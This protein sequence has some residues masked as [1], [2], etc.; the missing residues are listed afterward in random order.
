MVSIDAK[1]L[2]SS[3]PKHRVIDSIEKRWDKIKVFTKID[4]YHFMRIITMLLNN[5]Y[6]QYNG[7]FWKQIW[8]VATGMSSSVEMSDYT[9]E[10][11]MEFVEK[12]LGVEPIFSAKYVDDLLYIIDEDE[13]EYMLTLFNSFDPHM[14]FT[15]EYETNGKLPFLDVEL[16]RMESGEIKTKWYRKPSSSDTILN[17]RSQHTL[18]QKINVANGLIKRI[19]TLTT[20]NPPT[21]NLPL[22]KEILMKN[23]YPLFIINKLFNDYLKKTVSEN[24]VMNKGN[25]VEHYRSIQ[26]V[27]GLSNKLAKCIKSFTNNIQI[28]FKNKKTVKSLH[29][30]VKDKIRDSRKSQL[31]YAIQCGDCLLIYF[32]ITGKYLITR[33]NQHRGDVMSFHKLREKL[34]LHVLTDLNE[35]RRLADIE[36]NKKKKAEFEKLIKYAEK[37]GITEHHTKCQHKINFKN[38]KVV[39]QEKNRQKLEVLEILHIKSNENMNKK[40]DSQKLKAYD[41][42]ITQLKNRKKTVRH[43]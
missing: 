3:I 4:K 33:I 20:A 6:C 27:T 39:Q 23:N 10:D 14:E 8:G 19:C 7:K 40:E 18:K 9:M 35:I 5:S 17:Y 15:C 36:K 11:V 38:A 43:D 41:G 30:K 13:V 26:M 37:S 2:F 21:E 28:C 25:S 1:S 24:D 42:I 22:I 16:M 34:N 31:V 29:T 12:E 32:G